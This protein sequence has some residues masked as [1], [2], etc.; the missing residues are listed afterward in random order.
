MVFLGDKVFLG[1]TEFLGDKVALGTTDI[2]GDYNNLEPLLKVRT[3]VPCR[4]GVSDRCVSKYYTEEA[5]D[6]DGNTV[7]ILGAFDTF[8]S[9]CITSGSVANI[10]SNDSMAESRDSC[11]A[12]KR[13]FRLWIRKF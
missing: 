2:P 6:R 3:I 4:R 12:S 13:A 1:T 11:V 9:R 10:V 7:G 5:P 8:E